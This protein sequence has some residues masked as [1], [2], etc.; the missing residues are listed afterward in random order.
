MGDF[1]RI[2][3]VAIII[4]LIACIVLVKPWR[5]KSETAK[6]LNPN[7]AARLAEMQ[8]R[9]QRLDAE[10]K[11]YTDGVNALAEESRQML[12]D[13][14]TARE[15]EV[16]AI[17]KQEIDKA[18]DE[19]EAESRADMQQSFETAKIKLESRFNENN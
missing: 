15:A 17:V 19:L 8:S 11:D 5:K 9:K 10:L 2:I 13:Y 18:L 1:L 6:S 14:F 7:E 16:K 4:A 3:N 12:D